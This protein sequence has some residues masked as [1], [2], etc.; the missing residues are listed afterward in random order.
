MTD[1][2]LVWTAFEDS[3]YL[4]LGV[5][6]GRP[7]QEGSFQKVQIFSGSSRSEILISPS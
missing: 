6:R 1:L 5:E 7:L 2:A 3:N 4:E